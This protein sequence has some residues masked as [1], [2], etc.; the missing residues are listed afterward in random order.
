VTIHPR[1]M[2]EQKRRGALTAHQ[3]GMKEQTFWSLVVD[4]GLPIAMA[5]TE[6]DAHGQHGPLSG[7]R[8]AEILRLLVA[9]LIEFQMQHDVLPG[10]LQLYHHNDRARPSAASF[11]QP[12]TS[13]GEVSD[14]SSTEAFAATVE[15]HDLEESFS[16]EGFGR[17]SIFDQEG[18]S[19]VEDGGVDGHLASPRAP[20]HRA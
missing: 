19:F 4:Y 6:P 15:S 1:I 5:L 7:Q 8:L 18:D 13:L 9:Q 11:V 17:L 12:P 10:H 16:G 3:R 2:P 14:A 20:M